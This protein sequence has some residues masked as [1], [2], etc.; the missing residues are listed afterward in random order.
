MAF[1]EPGVTPHYGPS[2][3]VRLRHLDLHLSIEPAERRWSGT[4]RLHIKALPLFAG[5]SRFDLDMVQVRSVT[6]G[7]GNDLD[8][9]HDDAVLEVSHR[10][11]TRQV[12][13]TFEGHDPTAGIY[14]TGPTGER[15]ERQHMAWT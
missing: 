12:V 14:F 6:D 8:Y 9:V 1:P 10:K 2:R 5:T 15:P 11:S 4:A 3:T 13:V 7:K